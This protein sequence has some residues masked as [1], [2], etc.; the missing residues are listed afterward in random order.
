MLPCFLHAIYS[1]RSNIYL[2]VRKPKSKSKNE[3]EI[4]EEN[5]E[6]YNGYAFTGG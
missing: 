3:N 2:D 6:V 1:S 5:E 4:G